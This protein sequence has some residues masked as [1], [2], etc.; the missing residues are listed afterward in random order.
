MM[1][2]IKDGTV[3]PRIAENGC[4]SRQIE[5]GNLGFDTFIFQGN[6]LH[7]DDLLGVSRP[8]DIRTQTKI[9]LHNLTGEIDNGLVDFV[10]DKGCSVD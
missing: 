4:A 7:Q 10:L 6:L 1:K 5:L 3:I 2:S 9:A 8:V